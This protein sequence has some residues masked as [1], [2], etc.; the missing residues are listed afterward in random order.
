MSDDTSSGDRISGTDSQF[1]GNGYFPSTEIT[2]INETNMS[3]YVLESRNNSFRVIKGVINIFGH[4]PN[5][6]LSFSPQQ[7][8]QALKK[9]GSY[10]SQVL[11]NKESQ[12]ELLWWVKNI[13]L[14]NGK[15]LIQLPAQALLQTDALLTGWG[16]SGKK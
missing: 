11:L 12:L 14:Y 2:T 6:N 3:G 9:N 8:I 4:S 1:K 15:I 13:K 7:Q 10:K 16:Q 5:K